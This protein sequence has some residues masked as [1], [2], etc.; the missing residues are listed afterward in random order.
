MF[1][2]AGFRPL[3]CVQYGMMDVQSDPTVPSAAQLVSQ[4]LDG[5]WGGFAND[6]D[7]ADAHCDDWPRDPGPNYATIDRRTQ[8][9]V[10]TKSGHRQARLKDELILTVED[11]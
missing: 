1:L 10:G 11:W 9:P 4:S 6:I 3:S 7:S 5:L 2:E 8:V